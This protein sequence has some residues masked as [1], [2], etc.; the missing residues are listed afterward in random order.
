MRQLTQTEVGL[1]TVIHI[2]P[3]KTFNFNERAAVELWYSARTTRM[4]L[5]DVERVVIERI[6]LARA[7]GGCCRSVEPQ[8][9]C[10][11]YKPIVRR[12]WYN[13]PMMATCLHLGCLSHSAQRRHLPYSRYIQL[14]PRLNGLQAFMSFTKVKYFYVLTYIIH[15]I[16]HTNFLCFIFYTNH[17][18]RMCVLF[19]S[20]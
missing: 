6:I 15:L 5:Q 17:K 13:P 3:I 18:K 2:V 11:V 7:A 9:V 14:T 1:L 4:W 19:S 16:F 10:C 8:V 12:T 20:E